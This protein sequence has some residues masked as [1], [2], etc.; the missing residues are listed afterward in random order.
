MQN[1]LILAGGESKRFGSDKTLIEYQ[2]YASITHFLFQRLSEIFKTVQIS[3]KSQ[4]FNPPLPILEDDFDEFC[5]LF[6]LA[7]LD[8]F[9][10]SPVFIIAADTPFVT[11]DTIKTLFSNLNSHQICLA[12]D[13]LKTHY[14]CGFFDPSVSEIARNLIK[15]KEKMVRLLTKV[16][17]TKIIK[18]DDEKQFL[19]INTKQDLESIL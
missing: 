6:V 4:K 1:A 17:D 9:F 2:N 19:N 11:K 13:E 15:N 7:N 12:K 14:L 18:F 10:N 8:K 5:P 16:C 3:A